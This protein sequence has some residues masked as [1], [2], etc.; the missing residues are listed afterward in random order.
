MNA[1]AFHP[2]WVEKT[3]SPLYAVVAIHGG[4]FNRDGHA[5]FL[6]RTSTNRIWF[7]AG[8]SA[9]TLATEVQV[10]QADALSDSAV[11]D[12]NGDG[13]TDLVVSETAT[14]TLEVLLSNGDGTF[15]APVVTA[16]VE[17]PTRF[18]IGQFDGDGKADVIFLSA[19]G[20]TVMHGIGNG[21]FTSG[22][23]QTLT[24]DVAS[25][26][27][28]DFDGNGLADIVLTRRDTLKHDVY[29]TAIDGTLDS[30]VV[31]AG[32]STA[33][34]VARAAD[35]DGGGRVDLVSAEF[36]GNTVTVI[37]NLGGRQWATPQSY[38]AAP[39]WALTLGNAFD[40]AVADISGDGR[41]D[42]V[43]SLTNMRGFAT[44]QSNA[45][46]SL[47]APVATKVSASY[48][49]NAFSFAIATGD[50]D[51]DQ[52]P[53]VA[54]TSSEYTW[55]V[56]PFRNVSGDVTLSLATSHPVITAGQTATFTVTISDAPGAWTRYEAPS[57]DPT[58]EVVISSGET[59]LGRATPV[60]RVA[61]I[62]VSGLALGDY[63]VTAHYAGDSNFR[64]WDSTSV[65]QKVTTGRTT[66]ELTSSMA[67]LDSPYAEGFRLDLTAT[68]DIA[69]I[70]DG[71]FW[72]YTDGVRSTYPVG[73]GPSYSEN[74]L[75]PGTHA[76]RLEFEGSATHPPATSNVVTQVVVRGRTDTRLDFASE[77]EF[78]VWV[79]GLGGT[80]PGGYV[81]LF[82]WR[83]PIARQAVG[84]R[85]AIP[86]DRAGTHYFHAE[87]EGDGLYAPSTSPS[88]RLDIP[89]SG[90]RL[91][92]TATGGRIVATTT[93]APAG[94]RY[95]RIEQR[96][97]AGPWTILSQGA[98]FA[99][100]T[101]YN[102][103]AATPYSFRITALD[104]SSAVLATSN[105]DTAMLVTF[106]DDPIALDTPVKAL[107]VTEILAAINTLRDA[108]A[109]P[110]SE[111]SVA[112][113]RL[114]RAADLLA[115]YRALN[116]VRAI[117]GASA[118]PIPDELAAGGILR[119]QHLQELREALH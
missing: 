8:T 94:S 47:A 45:D 87:Y 35:L 19:T 86:R 36:D 52:R 37:R 11:A 76:F 12:V 27:V 51:G 81:T 63:E 101:E 25:I 42:V 105:V 3:K 102:P 95:Y 79:N 71:T 14:N 55:G 32:A 62:D 99:S 67:G 69:G 56:V 57:P 15:A 98:S 72:L 16:L 118:I 65:T 73:N 108:V 88:R 119:M 83:T 9:G 33:S 112:P 58:G 38:V 48:W 44:L 4:D 113:G 41:L 114:I 106:T 50:I 59:V 75:T 28:A 82:D 10:L 31:V 23:R 24:G 60:N 103:F 2:E 91:T 74:Y 90:F 39:S 13:R 85:F 78:L 7:L 104:S 107:H 97:E 18:A 5:D 80:A 30:P 110:R 46:G 70:I 43:V 61:T 29:F 40:L 66:L 20:M 100:W 34:N 64:P 68:S 54:V 111:T 53:D 22:V 26:T 115:L 84:T 17:S 77:T 116:E 6:V 109:L 89:Q 1:F 96:I 117:F 49:E 21:E 92:V 93:G